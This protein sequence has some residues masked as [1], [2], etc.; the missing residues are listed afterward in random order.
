M[1]VDVIVPTLFINSPNLKDRFVE[2]FS[3]GPGMPYG[4]CV[5]LTSLV[6]LNPMGPR[7]P[8]G[9]FVPLKPLSS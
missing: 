4:P 3:L 9:P 8:G 5:P 6:P 2:F 7:S 1:T